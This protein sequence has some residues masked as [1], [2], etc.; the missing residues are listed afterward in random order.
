MQLLSSNTNILIA[1]SQKQNLLT[2]LASEFS[3]ILPPPGT[4]LISHFPERSDPPSVIPIEVPS[5]SPILTPNT[6]PVWFSGV[7]FALGNNPF[8]V[9]ILNA[10]PESFATDLDSDAGSEALVDATEK[11]GEGLWAGSQLG[12][13]TGFQ[14]TSGARATWVGGAE[15]FSDKYATKEI[16][17]YVTRP[18]SFSRAN[19][20]C[21]GVKSGNEQFSKDV[22][23]WTFQESLVLRVD[24]TEHHLVNGS[25]P[26]EQYTTNDQIVFTAY[27]SRYN[28]KASKWEPYSGLNDLQLE[29]TMLDPHIRTALPPVEGFPGM[30]SVSFRAP[31]R[32]GVFK[33]VINY[34]RKGY[35]LLII[36]SYLHRLIVVPQMDT[37]ALFD[38]SARRASPPRRLPPFPQRRLALLRWRHQHQRRI[39][40]LLGLVAGRGRARGKEG[41]GTQLENRVDVESL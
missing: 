38:Y 17:K 35:V 9:P 22:A 34:K 18:F 6:S 10:P 3:L 29:F 15:L 21:R 31:D 25:Y 8:L 14:A 19:V 23:A 39:L 36:A 20:Q 16:S 4:P 41:Q 7:P 13:V 37:P 33:F 40:P 27:I 11:G 30:Y 1:L 26:L 28:A 12:V 24:H 32:H 5:S 2:S